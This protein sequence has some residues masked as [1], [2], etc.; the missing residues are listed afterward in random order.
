MTGRLRRILIAGNGIAAVTAAETLR[1]H[2]FD[3]ELT[4]VG[5]EQYAAYSRPA[6]S[7]EALRQADAMTAH[8]LPEP[9]LGAR[10]L[11]GVEAVSLDADRRTVALSTGEVIEFD[12]LVIAT[13]SRA[14][15]LAGLRTHADRELTVRSIPDAM[16][17]R[18]RIAERPDVVVV[19]SG[20]LAMEIASE[21]RR[22]G[23]AV[24]LVARHV[25]MSRH[26]GGYLGDMLTAAARSAGV[27]VR[28]S[29][30][31]S[32]LDGWPRVR[33]DGGAVVSGDALV[34]AIGDAPNLEWLTGSGLLADGALRTDAAGR[35]GPG[36]VAAGDVA[37]FPT[38][39]GVR[40]VP[41]WFTAIER[42]KT[43][44]RALLGDAPDGGA[45]QPYF[46][47]EQFGLNIRAVGELPVAGEPDLVDGDI[48]AHRALLR[49]E[50]GDRTA[51]GLAVNYPASVPKLRRLAQLAASPVPVS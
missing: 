5:A 14:K 41:L 18:R 46:W 4:M 15:R 17:L 9:D 32:V 7:K 35:V 12:G 34:T 8:L 25:P 22:V 11:L 3:G 45:P 13:G 16:E 6:L 48:D 20:P 50:H 26:L 19:G 36:I 23:C 49:W 43:A 24:T 21:C 37:A 1:L 10:T 30:T 33:L 27:E 42:A 39:R 29:R 31:V 38:V 47:T 2:G 40:R 44:A 51:T 28:L